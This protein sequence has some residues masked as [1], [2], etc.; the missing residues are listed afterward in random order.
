MCDYDDERRFN[1]YEH[2]FRK[3]TIEN[4]ILICNYNKFLRCE[5]LYGNDVYVMLQ[6]TRGPRTYMLSLD[7]STELK[8]YYVVQGIETR[9]TERRKGNASK[10]LNELELKAQTDNYGVHIQCVHSASLKTLLEKRNYRNTT[11]GGYTF[12]KTGG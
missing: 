2:K 1:A 6:C 9:P 7:K 4:M 12:Y 3:E 5:A 10:F 11:C 8:N